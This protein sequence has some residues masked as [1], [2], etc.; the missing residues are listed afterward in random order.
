MLASAVPAICNVAGALLMTKFDL[1][2]E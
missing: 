2:E 1:K